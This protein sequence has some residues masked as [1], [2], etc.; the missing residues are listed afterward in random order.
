MGKILKFIVIA[1]GLS[2]LTYS[3]NSSGCIENQSSIPLAG[4]YANTTL[5]KIAVDSISIGGVGAPNDSMIIENGQGVSQVY[6]PFRSSKTTT[7]FFIRY[8]QETFRNDAFNDTITF[9]YKSIPYFVSEECG[10][11]YYYSISGFKYTRHLIDSISI[12]DTLI[13]NTDIERIKIF[14]RTAE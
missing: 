2:A 1:I 4:F 5:Q 10:A 7:G 12:I 13:T 8:E 9:E 3:C 14:F 11:M 6:L